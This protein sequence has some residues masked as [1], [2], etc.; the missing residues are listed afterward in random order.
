MRRH[1]NPRAPRGC[2]AVRCACAQEHAHTETP[3]ARRRGR[4]P[5]RGGEHVNRSVSLH[6]LHD[7]SVFRR[8]LDEMGYNI[9]RGD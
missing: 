9:R 5:A 7:A 6:P 4:F 8:V 2:V 3:P 1:W